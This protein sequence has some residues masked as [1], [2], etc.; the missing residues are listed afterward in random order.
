MKDA[1]GLLY[2]PQCCHLHAIKHDISALLPFQTLK[3]YLCFI[4]V[5]LRSSPDMDGWSL[6][7]C[8]L[9]NSVTQCG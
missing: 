8:S 7:L 1:E 3:L 9:L 5:L 4:L 2:S 6:G